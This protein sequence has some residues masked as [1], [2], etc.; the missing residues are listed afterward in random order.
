VTLWVWTVVLF[1]HIVQAHSA[2]SLEGLVPPPIP[3]LPHYSSPSS[4][5]VLPGPQTTIL[6]WGDWLRETLSLVVAVCSQD[7]GNCGCA[8]G[9]GGHLALS[10]TILLSLQGGGHTSKCGLLLNLCPVQAISTSRVWPYVGAVQRSVWTSLR[11]ALPP[12]RPSHSLTCSYGT[13]AHPTQDTS[14][15]AR[16]EGQISVCLAKVASRRTQ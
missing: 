12:P 13:G 8:K 9:S 3:T 6:V 5:P 2:P 11:S 16:T 15:E 10:H 4:S 14:P 1:P 7:S